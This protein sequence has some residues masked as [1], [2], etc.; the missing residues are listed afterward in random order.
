[1]HGDDRP[2]DRRRPLPHLIAGSPPAIVPADH[3]EI[4]PSVDAEPDDHV[5]GRLS[6]FRLRAH[7]GGT[8][9]GAVAAE[10]NRGAARGAEQRDQYALPEVTD[11][12]ETLTSFHAPAVGALS[13][14]CAS[15]APGCPL[16]SA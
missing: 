9:A 1:V 13:V 8:A 10:A 3:A 2:R 11:V 16:L 7:L 4:G 5:A 15:S 14:P 12:L 6:R